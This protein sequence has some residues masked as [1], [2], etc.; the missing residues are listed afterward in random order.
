MNALLKAKSAYSSASTP[1]RTSKNLEYDVIARIT[2]RMIAAANKGRGGFAELAEVL[3]DN[4]RMW[5][6]FEADVLRDENQLPAGLKENLVYLAAFTKEH[7]S[8]VMSR[9]E[10]VR[11]LV[12]IN[13]AI[14]RG[15]RSGAS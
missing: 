2:R 14:L 7:T 15:L 8:K 4:R 6:L 3:H 10:T 9:K 5:S 13:T 11:P 1:T 12:E